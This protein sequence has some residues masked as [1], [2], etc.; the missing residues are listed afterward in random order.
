M[1]LHP[2]QDLATLCNAARAEAV[3]DDMLRDRLC[4]KLPDPALKRELRR[5]KQSSPNATLA[6]L[7]EEAPRWQ[8][9]EGSAPVCSI[10]EQ[11]SGP[12][13]VDRQRQQVEE[14]SARLSRMQGPHCYSCG[15]VGHFARVCPTNNRQH[16]RRMRAEN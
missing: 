11:T 16:Q 13:E 7:R 1:F 15:E 4:E 12:T 2:L 10:Q 5:V 14:L 9:E 8:Q 6:D 3:P